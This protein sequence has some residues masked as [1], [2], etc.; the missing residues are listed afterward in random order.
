[1]R[2]KF[3]KN[4]KLK[5]PSCRFLTYFLHK[6]HQRPQME[7]SQRKDSASNSLSKL[8]HQ[9]KLV[10]N[11][12]TPTSLLTCMSLPKWHW[13]PIGSILKIIYKQQYL[14]KSEYLIIKHLTQNFFF[15]GVTELLLQWKQVKP[16]TWEQ[17]QART[18]CWQQST[19]CHLHF[20]YNKNRA[21]FV[22]VMAINQILLVKY[23]WTLWLKSKMIQNLRKIM[24]LLWKLWIWKPSLLERRLIIVCFCSW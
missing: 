19:Q 21:Y 18:Q 2:Y 24:S 11:S 20:Q 13:L 23:F 7:K 9:P 5:R 8:H 22:P 6:I 15:F 4:E 16:W 10:V 17:Y 3:S 14:N 1:M 12:S